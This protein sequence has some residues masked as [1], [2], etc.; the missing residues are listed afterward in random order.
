MS[1]KLKGLFGGGSADHD[2]EDVKKSLSDFSRRFVDANGDGI[3][4]DEVRSNFETVVKRASPETLQRATASAIQNLPPAQRSELDQMLKDRQQGKNLVDIQ[5]TGESNATTAGGGGAA[6]GG[7]LDDLLGGLLGGGG[8]AGGGGIGDILGGLLGGGGGGGSNQPQ[9]GGGGLG[10][11][12]GGLLG[13]GDDQS[14][15]QATQKPADGG[16]IGDLLSGPLGKMIM[17]GI[18]AFAAKEM[19]GK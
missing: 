19:L 1:D 17:G 10:D 6:G 18:A 5:R 11:I 3:P 12:L 4:D 14:N 9:S 13:G 2:D 16:G 7:G 8:A 15:N